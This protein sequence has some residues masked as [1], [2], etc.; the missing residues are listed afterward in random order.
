MV[1]CAAILNFVIILD[2]GVTAILKF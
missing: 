1:T 2:F